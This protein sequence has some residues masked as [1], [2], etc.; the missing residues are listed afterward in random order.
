MLF[1]TRMIRSPVI[2]PIETFGPELW[3]RQRYE[4]MHAYDGVGLA[5]PKS[6]L[7]SEFSSTR[8]P[9]GAGA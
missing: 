1:F 9:V 3:P 2:P 4:T 8:S 7:R 6:G 5:G